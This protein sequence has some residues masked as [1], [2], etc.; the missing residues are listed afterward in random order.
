M[1]GGGVKTTIIRQDVTIIIYLII[2]LL[3]EG[4]SHQSK[5]VDF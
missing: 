2:I 3:F 1:F 4:L 5:L